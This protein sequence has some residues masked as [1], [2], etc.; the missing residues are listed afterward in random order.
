MASGH[1][2]GEGLAGVH[3]GFAPISGPGQTSQI[4]VPGLGVGAMVGG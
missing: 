1:A 3:F 2:V 4:H